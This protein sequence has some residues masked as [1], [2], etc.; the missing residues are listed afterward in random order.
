L[1]VGA[2]LARAVDGR[3]SKARPLEPDERKTMARYLGVA[4]RI[5]ILGHFLFVA[6]LGIYAAET[7]ARVF[8]YMGF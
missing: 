8:R 1:Q 3:Q 6:I 7:G 2:F 4:L 5:I